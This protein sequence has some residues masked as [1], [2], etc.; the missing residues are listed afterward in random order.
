MSRSTR[1][2]AAQ[3]PNGAAD[4]QAPAAGSHAREW[5]IRAALL[6][7]SLA[8]TFCVLEAGFRVKA[9]L[10]DR[11]LDAFQRLEGARVVRDPDARLRTADII[12]LS[13]NPR[14][15]YELIPGLEGRYRGG[16]IRVN[17]QGFRGPELSPTKPPG[18][19]RVAGIG[20]S[21]MFGW[22]VGEEELYLARLARLLAEREPGVRWEWINSAVPGYSTPIEVEVLEDRVLRYAPDLVIVGFVPNDVELPNFIRSPSPYLRLDRSYLGR[23]V[24]AL[25]KGLARTPDDRLAAAPRD[26]SEIPA[27][28]RALRGMT[29][30]VGAIERLGRLA[31]AR[32][33]EALVLAYPACP[34]EL[35][36]VSS[37]QG[38][39]CLESGPAFARWLADRELGPEASPLVLAPDDPHP[40]PLGH[41][42][43]AET[44]LAHLEQSGTLR[45][46]RRRALT[47]R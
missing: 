21:V 26:E 4:E 16:L 43:L 25:R 37:A 38:F 7:G 14:V 8:F 34:A 1:A 10:D 20:D 27:E 44:V 40:S 17:A 12:R 23:F 39:L 36:A 45:A 22:G 35:R 6:L 29:A 47:A 5:T 11:E 2:E 18:T 9:F 42:V 46:L 19:V 15:I 31:D 41:S 30:V 13:R 28:Y 24:R 3:S 32:R 33:F